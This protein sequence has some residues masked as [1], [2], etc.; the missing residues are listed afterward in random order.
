MQPSRQQKI[1]TMFK[2]RRKRREREMYRRMCNNAKGYLD[3]TEHLKK[4]HK[5][6][7]KRMLKLSFIKLP[8]QCSC[9]PQQLLEL[10]LLYLRLSPSLGA[11]GIHGAI[12]AESLHV[13]RWCPAGN[14]DICLV[15]SGT[16][17]I[18][19]FRSDEWG[20]VSLVRL[21]ASSIGRLV[22]S[23]DSRVA[24]AILRRSF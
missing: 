1:F 9:L 16:R 19:I 20:G 10:V 23:Q 21:A 18:H 15:L 11:D 7:G 22:D 24:R 5:N 3:V 6:G 12:V 4:K 14:I 17:S 2:G 13:S 8:S